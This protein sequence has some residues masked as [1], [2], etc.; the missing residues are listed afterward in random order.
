MFQMFHVFR[1]ERLKKFR[2]VGT[3][4]RAASHQIAENFSSQPLSETVEHGTA[5]HL[6][7]NNFSNLSYY[8]Y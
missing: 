7:S 2:V 4:S 8:Y 3:G 5:L 1:G 6:F